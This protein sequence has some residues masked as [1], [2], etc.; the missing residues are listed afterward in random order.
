MQRFSPA[1]V[2][3][4]PPPPSGAV[5]LSRSLWLTS[6]GTGA[7]AVI[8]VFL[9]RDSQL[10][11]LNAMVGE[12]DATVETSTSDSLAALVF[13][14][15]L[16][17][18][19]LVVGLEGLL[20]RIMLHRRRWARVAMLLFLPAH[21]AV[22]LVAEAFLAGPG[23]EGAVVGSFAMDADGAG[24]RWLL[25]VQLCLAVLAALTSFGPG[26]KEW[27]SSRR[28]QPSQGPAVDRQLDP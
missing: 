2:R 20:L 23:I 28:A 21:V 13:W 4:G 9:S 10:E 11:H 22:A 6:F 19:V 12:L 24:V 14:S 8:L 16:G 25:A 18:I 26:A 27:F 3:R 7:L 1:P 17:L 15:S 5:K